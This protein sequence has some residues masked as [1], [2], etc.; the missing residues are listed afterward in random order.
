MANSVA[1]LIVQNPAG[2]FASVFVNPHSGGTKLSIC[3]TFN[4]IP[5]LP[6]QGK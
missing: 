6:P 5:L 3:K 1:S 2:F 4:F